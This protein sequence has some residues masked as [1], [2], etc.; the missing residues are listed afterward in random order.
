MTHTP[1]KTALKLSIATLALTAMA[2]PAAFAAP[3]V[4]TKTEAKTASTYTK[5]AQDSRRDRVRGD[6]S[7]SDRV[8][9]DIHRD[10]RRVDHR[11]KR[12]HSSRGHYRPY[13]SKVG[14]S[15]SFGNSG[16][17]PY[18]WAPSNYGFYRPSRVSISGYQRTTQCHR[19]I[20]SGWH[21]GR[22]VPISVRECYN[23]YDG[24]YI[25]QGSETLVHRRF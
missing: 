13:R 22:P 15:F 19:V 8:R 18:R 16:Y 25:V 11:I 6:R 21:H 5:V 3:A 2:V 17:S 4:S 24:Y 23:P 7:R 1:F 9:R 20:R 14:I 12:S 10:L